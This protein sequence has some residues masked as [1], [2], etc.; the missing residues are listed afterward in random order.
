MSVIKTM[1]IINNHVTNRH[2]TDDHVQSQVNIVFN[3]LT[4]FYSNNVSNLT[5]CHLNINSTRHKFPPLAESLSNHV[6]DIL[7]LREIKIDESFPMKQF[8]VE[9]YKI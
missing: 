5:F 9:G 7:M 1:H 6:L 3:A 2:V 4:K 8:S